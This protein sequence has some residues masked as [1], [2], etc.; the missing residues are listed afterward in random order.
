MLYY[1]FPLFPFHFFCL[2]LVSLRFSFFLNLNVGR[3]A[4][5]ITPRPPLD[6][7]I[8]YDTRN[9]EIIIIIREKQQIRYHNFLS[10]CQQLVVCIFIIYLIHFHECRGKPTYRENFKERKF[11]EMCMS[12]ILYFSYVTR[13]NMILLFMIANQYYHINSFLMNQIENHYIISSLVKLLYIS[14]HSEGFSFL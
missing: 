13:I 3:V 7:L 14:E 2:G 6:P 5:P 11:F 1:C 4:T 9:T 8:G 12:V 10:F